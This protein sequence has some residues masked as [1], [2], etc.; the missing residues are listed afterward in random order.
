[1]P[2]LNWLY[3]R[4]WLYVLLILAGLELVG[5]VH[6][7][8]G[9]TLSEY[10]WVKTQA[11][12]MRVA[13]GALLVWLVYHWLFNRPGVGLTWRDGVAVWVGLAVGLVSYM[14]VHRQ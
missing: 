4:L 3:S 7:G 10:T 8:S 12:P 2:E 11:A 1:M 5:I 9:Y 14:Y 6:H 13:L